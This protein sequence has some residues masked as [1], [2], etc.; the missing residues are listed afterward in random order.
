[1]EVIDWSEGALDL[2]TPEDL[3]SLM[4]GLGSMH[5]SLAGGRKSEFGAER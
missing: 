5:H 4:V 3:A 1:M 2:D